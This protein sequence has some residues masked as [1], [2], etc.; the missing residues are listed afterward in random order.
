MQN[1]IGNKSD[2]SID[3]I[4]QSC[5]KL[6]VFCAAASNQWL[7]L[8]GQLAASRA[9]ANLD[10]DQEIRHLKGSKKGKYF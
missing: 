10:K 3:P 7:L 1:R 2:P 4:V 8:L 9:F 6:G 5:Y